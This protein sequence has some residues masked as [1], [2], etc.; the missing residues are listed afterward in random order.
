MAPYA[1]GDE[2]VATLR[3]RFEDGSLT[4]AEPMLDLDPVADA[5]LDVVLT[6]RNVHDW[7][8]PAIEQQ[9]GFDRGE[10]VA[11]ILRTLK[12]GGILGVVD[13]RTPEEG[14]NPTTHRINEQFVII[15][16]A[17]LVSTAPRSPGKETPPAVSRSCR[18]WRTPS[19][20]PAR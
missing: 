2:G 20:T 5:S 1:F 8:I 15:P 12:P 11:A 14:I 9:F 6:V 16:V 7:Y 3:K 17:D 18:A 10:I 13:A 4:N 19:R